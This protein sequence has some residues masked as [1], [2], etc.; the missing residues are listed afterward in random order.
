MVV[1][2]RSDT[3][4]AYFLSRVIE[5]GVN[6]ARDNVCHKSRA[7]V[8]LKALGIVDCFMKSRD[9]RPLKERLGE[10]LAP[11]LRAMLEEP[12]R[13]RALDRIVNFLTSA[14]G[15]EQS[16]DGP[17]DERA[18]DV[19][20][21]AADPFEYGVFD[22]IR[23]VALEEANGYLPDLLKN[24]ARKKFPKVNEH[25][26]EEASSACILKLWSWSTREWQ[27]WLSGERILREGASNAAKTRKAKLRSYLTTIGVNTLITNYRKLTKMK[28]WPSGN[29]SEESGDVF[30]KSD[31]SM[32]RESKAIE[33]AKELSYMIGTLPAKLQQAILDHY[34]Q[35]RPVK[36]IAE[37]QGLTE[38]AIYLRLKKAE[39]RL[40]Q[41]LDSEFEAPR[42]SNVGSNGKG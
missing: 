24:I 13:D 2:R 1:G 30:D 6:V 4:A 3:A 42:D 39:S 31:S 7:K 21:I 29:D 14:Q 18:C 20:T 35:G 41:L 25:D 9:Q 32:Q 28:D 33:K 15:V 27:S 36:D 40:K 34:F 19:A 17:D 11:I 37:E 23:E 16:Y 10:S 5:W 12:V 22:L 8:D 38:K 26:V